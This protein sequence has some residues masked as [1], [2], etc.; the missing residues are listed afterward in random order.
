M[1]RRIVDISVALRQGIK[2][3]PPWAL[4]QIDHHDHRMT[5][6]PIAEYFGITMDQLPEGNYAAREQA[7]PDGFMVACFPVKVH[8]GSA[9]WTRAVAIFEE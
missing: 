3:D 2:S 5:A 9:G 4:P 7:R 8:Q 1:P 6:P